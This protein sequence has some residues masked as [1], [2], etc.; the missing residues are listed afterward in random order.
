MA[1]LFFRIFKIICPGGNAFLGG[2]VFTDG[3]AFLGGKDFPDGKDFPCVRLGIP[4]RPA[5]YPSTCEAALE[6]LSNVSR[7]SLACLSMIEACFNDRSMSHRL[8]HVST[9]ETLC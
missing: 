4:L 9:G 5:W 8:K 3:K 1:F 6:C 7:M 2:R